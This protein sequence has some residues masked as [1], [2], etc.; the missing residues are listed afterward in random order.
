MASLLWCASHPRNVCWSATLVLKIS[1]HQGSPFNV[2][3][4]GFASLHPDWMSI[5]MIPNSIHHAISKILTDTSTCDQMNII[6]SHNSFFAHTFWSTRKGGSV[7][8]ALPFVHWLSSTRPS[9]I[10]WLPRCLVASGV[11]CNA[12]STQASPNPAGAFTSKLHSKTRAN[13]SFLLNMQ[14]TWWQAK[15]VAC[16]WNMHSRDSW[17]HCKQWTP[18]GWWNVAVMSCHHPPFSGAAPGNSVEKKAAYL[19]DT[20]SR[21]ARR[22]PQIERKSDNCK[23]T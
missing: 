2:F 6:S 19:P 5:M 12:P 21:P 17:W 1:T 20:W 7:E 18:R 16:V 4:V 9:A 14:V 10:A 3:H 8:H 22:L 23:D 15:R 13:F 11:R